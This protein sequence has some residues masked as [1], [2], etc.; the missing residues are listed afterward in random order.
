M[1]TKI[2]APVD[3][4]HIESLERALDCAADLAK[5][6]GLANRLRRPSRPRGPTTQAQ[7]PEE[8]GK[9]L[10]AF[11]EGEVDKH[12]VCGPKRILQLRMTQPPKLTMRCFVRSTKREPILVVMAS[13]IPGAMDYIW[14]SNGGKVA[15]HAK[16][17]GDGRPIMRSGKQVGLG[18]TKLYLLSF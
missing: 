14:P 7:N 17:L 16:L 5:H 13:H 8:F 18:N 4:A 2:M 12:G 15:G 3:L 6:Y 11:V 10:A 9:L 1:F